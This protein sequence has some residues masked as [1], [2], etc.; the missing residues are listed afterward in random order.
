MAAPC[1]QRGGRQNISEGEISPTPSI[2]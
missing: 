2:C 1:R